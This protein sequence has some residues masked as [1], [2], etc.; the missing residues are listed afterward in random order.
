MYKRVILVD[1]L[2]SIVDNNL[3]YVE[4]SYS[5]YYRAY[6]VTKL[7]NFIYLEIIAQIPWGLLAPKP[8]G[9][10]GKEDICCSFSSRNTFSKYFLALIFYPWGLLA[11]KPPG[12]DGKGNC[13]INRKYVIPF[14]YQE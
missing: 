14:V 9:A 3:N 4:H 6:S 7:R 10:D 13:L 2:D 11:P 8:P 12:A 5:N 1:L